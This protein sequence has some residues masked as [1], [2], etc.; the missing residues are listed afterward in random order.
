M[1]ERPKEAFDNSKECV[2]HNTI[3]ASSDQQVKIR[4]SEEIYPSAVLYS[5]PIFSSSTPQLT[6]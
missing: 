5:L 1:W 4:T 6:L 3:Q 2:S